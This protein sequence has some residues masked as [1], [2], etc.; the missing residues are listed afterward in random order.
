MT[1]TTTEI[2]AIDGEYEGSNW[3][4]N[5]WWPHSKLLFFTVIPVIKLCSSSRMF[6]FSSLYRLSFLF[7]TIRNVSYT[8]IDII[9]ASCVRRESFT[10]KKIRTRTDERREESAESWKS[11]NLD[12]RP[13]WYEIWWIN[14]HLTSCITFISFNNIKYKTSSDYS[15]IHTD[16]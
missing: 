10:G 13:W 3:R 6:F 9:Q 11:E 2:K 5:E 16:T 7:R 15:Y 12:T 1:Q 8:K 4:T 14:P